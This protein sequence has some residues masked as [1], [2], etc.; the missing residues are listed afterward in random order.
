MSSHYKN[1]IVFQTALD[2]AEEAYRLTA[3]YPHREWFN[4]VD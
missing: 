4:L 3:G 1:L 2:L